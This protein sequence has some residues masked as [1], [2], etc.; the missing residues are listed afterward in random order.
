MCDLG[1]ICPHVGIYHTLA[2]VHKQ[3][4]VPND[5]IVVSV[6]DNGDPINDDR[7]CVTARCALRRGGRGRGGEERRGEGGRG[8]EGRG[9]RGG[10]EGE[11]CQPGYMC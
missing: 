9:R 7:V 3:L 5:S 4:V 10:M 2:L 6:C 11:R 1:G 8:G